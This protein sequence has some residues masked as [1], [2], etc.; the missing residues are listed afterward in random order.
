MQIIC[1]GSGSSG[2][3]F[4]IRQGTTAILL[5]AGLPSATVRRHLRAC[6]IS[7]QAV[8]AIVLSHEHHDHVRGLAG[9]LEDDPRPIIATRG[10]WQA[11]N[12]GTGLH[13]VLLQPGVPLTLGDI[14]LHPIPVT[15]DAA[16]PVGFLIEDA[17]TRIA[18]FTDLGNVTTEVVTALRSAHLLVLEANY[19][20]ELL[21]RGPYPPWLKA[22]IS[23][24]LGHLSNES[25]AQALRRAVHAPHQEIWLAHL[26][27][28]NNAPEIAERCVRTALGAIPNP[29]RALPR[30]GQ[31]VVW[32]S[33]TQPVQLSLR[34]S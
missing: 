17:T 32:D 11:L 31:P 10:T 8:Q 23:S 22:R 30:R 29:I 2:N 1:L 21:R 25:C 3:A 26:S 18:L 15:H 33:R 28:Q 13:W 6:G 34:F 4:F 12:P 24:P 19:D 16:E 9:L 7:M 14:V 27:E 5:D 20:T